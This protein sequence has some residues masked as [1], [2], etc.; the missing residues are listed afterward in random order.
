MWP[1]KRRPV[2]D[3]F[4]KGFRVQR[5]G[6][7]AALW[8]VDLPPA[9]I[10][11]YFR[12]HHMTAMEL[13]QESGDKRFEPS[14]FFSEESEGYSVGWYSRRTG[15]K[16]VRRFSSLA[17]AATDYLLFSLGKGR[18]TPSETADLN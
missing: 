16:C 11:T 14:S 3:N 7:P 13:M 1:W 18:W 17:D 5:I 12:E 15:Y 4:P 9:D 8:L 6:L 2:G 10:A